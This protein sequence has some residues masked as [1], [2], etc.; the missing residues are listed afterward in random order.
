MCI[1]TTGIYVQRCR[2]GVHPN[3]DYLEGDFCFFF[4]FSLLFQLFI[5]MRVEKK[6]PIV[7]LKYST[8]K[9]SNQDKWY[10]QKDR[11][12]DQGNRNDSSETDTYTYG[13]LITSRA[14]QETPSGKAES[15]EQIV[16]S[17]LD[18]HVHKDEIYFMQF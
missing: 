2:E 6:N 15:H 12:A 17:Q 7:L 8:E 4:Y 3:N 13:Q 16:L 14:T 5:N 18:L 10:W 1:H 11:H 9:Y